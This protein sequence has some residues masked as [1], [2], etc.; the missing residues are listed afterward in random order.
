MKTIALKQ[1][2]IEPAANLKK[3]LGLRRLLPHNNLEYQEAM[4]AVI[5]T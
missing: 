5:I 2:I 1:K 4:K 3:I